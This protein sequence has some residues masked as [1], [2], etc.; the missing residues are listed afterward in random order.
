MNNTK[1]IIYIRLLEGVENKVPCEA[2]H[3]HSDVYKIIRNR[4]LDLQE[5]V[6]SI[7]EFFPGDIVKCKRD[8]DK[9]IA[10]ELLSSQ[11]PDR[12]LHQLIFLVVESLGKIKF[13][14]LIEFEDEIEQINKRSDIIQLKHPVVQSWIKRHC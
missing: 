14:D 8:E 9:F 11:F 3:I 2:E 1:R 5:D 4:Y 10:K 6:T 7:W 13:E 12:K